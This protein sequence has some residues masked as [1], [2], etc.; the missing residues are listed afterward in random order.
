M[1]GHISVNV[2]GKQ[3]S[4]CGMAGQSV[5]EKYPPAGTRAIVTIS[6]PRPLSS[7]LALRLV[8]DRAAVLWVGLLEEM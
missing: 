1:S 7:S 4:Q 6:P 2:R 8:I 5:L 3:D